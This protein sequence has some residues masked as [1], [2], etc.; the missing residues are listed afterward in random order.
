MIE[1]PA[2]FG[3][4][5]WAIWS[6]FLVALLFATRFYGARLRDVLLGRGLVS[7]DPYR[8]LDFGMAA[9]LGTWLIMLVAGTGQTLTIGGTIEE[10]DMTRGALFFLGLVSLIFVRFWIFRVS[11]LQVFGFR[12]ALPRSAAGRGLLFLLAAL[13]LIQVITALTFLLRGLP[14][15]GQDVVEFFKESVAGSN[16]RAVT[17][18]AVY[19]TLV[20]PFCEETIF[21]GYLYGALK[22]FAGAP[23]A[24]LA[25]AG[26]FA[27]IHL[28]ADAF[29][30][31]F[32][33]ALCLSLAYEATGSL[34]VPMIMHS[35]F[36][37]GNLAVMYAVARSSG[38]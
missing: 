5:A 2:N 15:Q 29:G 10:S 1:L 4:A 30:P 38:G 13:P 8:P 31:L 16:Y 21:R 22:R 23:F 36:N 37:A 24:L 27:S 18:T 20:A 9:A 14:E 35:I 33:L 17:L 26:L 32:V 25:S 7:T 11:P 3:F 12:L 6:V 19:A 34:A 28:S